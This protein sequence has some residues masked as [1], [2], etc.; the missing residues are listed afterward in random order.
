MISLETMT[1]LTIHPIEVECM[2][3]GDPTLAQLMAVNSNTI[4][5][6]IG[7]AQFEIQAKNANVQLEEAVEAVATAI[8]KLHKHSKINKE[9]A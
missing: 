5:D 2:L 9:S 8:K 3:D 1:H 6:D 7:M 4:K